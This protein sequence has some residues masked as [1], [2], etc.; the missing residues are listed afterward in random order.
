MGSGHTH[1]HGAGANER[2]LLWALALTGGFMVAEVVA[3]FVTG[4]LALLSDAAHMFTD[5]AAL[6]VALAASRIARHPADRRRTY[7]Y[8]RF[9]I[10]AAV[11]NASLLVLVAIYILSEAWERFRAP[12]EGLNSPSQ[13]GN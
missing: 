11:F 3:A 7:G 4:S 2:A 8:Y 13:P 1:R 5:V 10:L 9:E 12:P 6:A